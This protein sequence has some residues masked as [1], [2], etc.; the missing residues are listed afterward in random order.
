MPEVLEGFGLLFF[1]SLP[2]RPTE[3]L[4]RLFLPSLLTFSHNLGLSLLLIF[5]TCY[6]ATGIFFTWGPA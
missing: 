3:W 1:C 4:L 2:S 6:T 5:L